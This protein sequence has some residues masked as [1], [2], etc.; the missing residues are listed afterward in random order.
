MSEEKL[1]WDAA[2]D[3]VNEVIDSYKELI[4]MKGV[5]PFFGLAFL[6]SLLNRYQA[7]D[8]TEELYKEMM[9]CQ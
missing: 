7:G 5:N 1:D 9:E 2:A 6:A 3:R 8:R 4:G